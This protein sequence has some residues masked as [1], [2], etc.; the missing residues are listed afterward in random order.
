MDRPLDRRATLRRFAAP[1]AACCA[2]LVWSYARTAEG[3]Q[4]P[5]PWGYRNWAFATLTYSDILALHEDRGAGA[6]ALPYLHDRIEYPVLLGF[7]MW[8]PSLI[9]P[10]RGGY[11]ALTFAVLALC[12]LGTLW[13]LCS[14][15]GTLPW[16][17]AAS[18][19]LL[20]YSALNWDLI[21]ILPLFA[22]LWLWA[23][24]RETAAVAVLTL[25]VW[26]KFFPL[27][28]L[29]VLLLKVPLNRLFKHLQVFAVLTLLIN[30][31]F[32]IAARDN[33]AW[34]FEYSR[35]RD[36]EPSLYLLAGVDRRAFV[37]AANQISLWVTLAAAASLA[38]IEWRT[39]SLDVLKGA[40][41][42]L[43]VFFIANKVYSP[44]YW[45]WVV[46]VLALA[47]APPWIASAAGCVALGDF[48]ISFM[49]LHLNS[50]WYDR[51]VFWP[52]VALRY[53]M[54]IICA[55][56]AFAHTTRKQAAI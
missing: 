12:A 5:S 15:P 38:A 33:W 27:L 25:A 20:V 53:A 2:L 7:S 26:T 14:L 36:I 43:C 39:R 3:T 6:H 45:I 49:R 8:W 13:V 23:R 47:A 34:F 9:E 56:W 46:A 54:L 1:A 16:A 32:A 30:L 55:I 52:M 19:A 29:G 11:F 42:L 10:N 44:Q 41:A 40:C 51:T 22:G 35:I 21:G 18:P 17:F 37:P 31:P 24:Q 4:H 50:G 48:A 28:V